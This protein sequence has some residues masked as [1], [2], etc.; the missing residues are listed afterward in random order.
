[1]GWAKY[2]LELWDRALKEGLSAQNLIYYY[3]FIERVSLP[4][5]HKRSGFFIFNQKLDN[6]RER[7]RI[8]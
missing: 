7:E 1:M 5:C 4:E 3:F 8:C 6:F 2:R